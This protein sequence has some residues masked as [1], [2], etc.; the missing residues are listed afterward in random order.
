MREILFC[1]KQIYNGKWA[2]SSCPLGVMHAGHLFYDFIPSTV[3]Q[4]IGQVDVHR[5][6]S[7]K[8]QSYDALTPGTRLLLFGL[9]SNLHLWARTALMAS[10]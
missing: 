5:K 9:I 3:G 10:G 7:S 4:Y 8:G 6:K 2:E 1:G